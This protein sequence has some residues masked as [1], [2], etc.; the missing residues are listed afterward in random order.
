MR[1]AVIA[2]L[3]AVLCHAL[4]GLLI[5]R[6]QVSD[7]EEGRAAAVCLK[8][9]EY[10]CIVLT[11]SVVK[12]QS[13]HR[14]V[15]IYLAHRCRCHFRGRLALLDHRNANAVN[16]GP[17]TDLARVL[18]VRNPVEPLAVHLCLGVYIVGRRKFSVQP[19]AHPLERSRS[20]LHAC[21][22]T[23]FLDAGPTAA[24]HIDLVLNGPRHSGR[25]LSERRAKCRRVGPRAAQVVIV[26][27]PTGPTL[28]LV[29][30]L[31]GEDNLAFFRVN[32]CGEI[33]RNIAHTKRHCKRK[34]HRSNAPKNSLS[35]HSFL[36]CLLFLNI[37]PVLP[38]KHK[39]PR[40]ETQV[41]AHGNLHY[42][43]FPFHD[44]PKSAKVSTEC[45]LARLPGKC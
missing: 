24:A 25:L 26:L 6:N 45:A 20:A 12:G 9:R 33:S 31:I 22:R 35:Y 37:S 2:E 27:G 39:M 5:A 41:F 15:R 18:T 44:H 16:V 30:H 10:L 43:T 4:H 21:N 36:F 13:D 29:L 7:H 34:C 19:D 32:R 1:P 8:C 14:T 42:N 40:N 38:E 3:H 23:V 11:R 28:S 17:H